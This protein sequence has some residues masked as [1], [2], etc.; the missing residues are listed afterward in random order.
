MSEECVWFQGEM[1]GKKEGKVFLKA[2]VIPANKHVCSIPGS[3]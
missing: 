1:K 2:A 3:Y